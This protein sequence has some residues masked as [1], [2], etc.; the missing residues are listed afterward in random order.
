MA[1]EPTRCGGMAERAKMTT[2]LRTLLPAG[3]G[4]AARRGRILSIALSAALVLGS[5]TA[6]VTATAPAARAATLPTGFQ[7]S[8]VFSGLTDPTAVRFAPG[9]RSSWPRSAGSSR[10]STP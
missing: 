6:F 10:C 8:V 2:Y 9:G 3:R 1:T 5:L 4:R 7:E